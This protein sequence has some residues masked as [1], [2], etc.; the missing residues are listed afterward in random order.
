MKFKNHLLVSAYC[1]ALATLAGAD[2][3]LTAY[4]R[5]TLAKLNSNEALALPES[6]E[7]EPGIT[8][9]MN[10]DFDAEKADVDNEVDTLFDIFYKD[11]DFVKISL[12]YSFDSEGVLTISLPTNCKAYKE[13]DPVSSDEGNT[14]VEL[15][16]FYDPAVDPDNT[17]ILQVPAGGGLGEW[18]YYL[19]GLD[20][21]WSELNAV[22][23]LAGTTQHET[24]SVSVTVKSAPCERVDLSGV[25]ASGINSATQ[26][27]YDSF[28][29]PSIAPEERHVFS[30]YSVNSVIW[31]EPNLSTATIQNLSVFSGVAF[32][33]AAAGTLISDRHLVF[34][35]HFP[36]PLNSEIRFHN[37]F[38]EVEL[39]TLKFLSARIGSDLQIGIVDPPLSPSVR[40][41]K[42]PS[43]GTKGLFIG[44]GGPVENE[45][46]VI[47]LH[48]RGHK[49]TPPIPLLPDDVYPSTL[50]PIH[51]TG[52]RYWSLRRL[53]D[54]NHN[55]GVPLGHHIPHDDRGVVTDMLTGPLANRGFS[56]RSLDTDSGCPNFFYVGGDLVLI[57]LNTAPGKSED[58]V[59]FQTEGDDIGHYGDEIWAAAYALDDLLDAEKS[60]GVTYPIPTEGVQLWLDGNAGFVH[61]GNGTGMARWM[62]LSGHQRDFVAATGGWSRDDLL[63]PSEAGAGGNRAVRFDGISDYLKMDGGMTARTV[64]A[65][66][67]YAEAAFPS[68]STGFDGLFTA[69]GLGS[70][71]EGLFFVGQGGTS[72]LSN[73]TG[74][75]SRFVN[76]LPV[77]SLPAGIPNLRQYNVFSG[78]A[79][80]GQPL[81]NWELGRDRGVANRL[82]SG[83]IAEVI[84]YDRVLKDA[85]RQE[86]EKYLMDKYWT[87]PRERL[88]LWLDS[89]VGFVH[90]GNGT[91]MARWM[92]LSGHQRDFVAA[93]GGWNPD[94]FLL[95]SEAGA[96]GNRAV[97]F[98]GIS[99][100]LK[101]DGGM[102]AKTVFAVARYAE[103]VFP[104]GSTGF[105]GLFTAGGLGSGSEGLFFVGQGGTSVLSNTTGF[106]SRFVN[107]T[108]TAA[109]LKLNQYNVFSGIATNGLLLTNWELGRDRGVA[110]R[111]WNGEIAEVIVYDRVLDDAERQ[112]VEQSLMNKFSPGLE[113]WLDANQGFETYGGG[114]DIAIWKDQSGHQRD[115]VSSAGK[116]PQLLQPPE[117]E[118]K[119][120]K[121]LRFDGNDDFMTM[122]DTMLAQT[123]F[124]VARNDNQL[125]GPHDEGLFTG[126]GMALSGSDI[127]FTG[128][129]G[130]SDFYQ[131]GPLNPR[132]VNG[133]PMGSNQ[134]VPVRLDQ[135]N[136]YSATAHPDA[137][138]CCDE[139]VVGRDRLLTNTVHRLW[140]GE[141]AEV[142]V[143]DHVLSDAERHEVERYLMD[144]Y[145]EVIPTRKLQLWLDANQGFEEDAGGLAVWRDRSGH[146]RDFVA[147]S[148]GESPNNLLPPLSTDDGGN[149]VVHAGGNRAVQFDGN[150]HY[151][152]MDGE[153]SAKTVFAVARYAEAAFPSEESTGFDGLFTAGGLGS[154]PEGLFFVGQGGT[155]ALSNTTGFNS[156]FVNGTPT[157]AI[158]KLNQY[159]VFSG[160]ATS[161]LLLTNWELGRDRGVANRLWDGEI[162]EVIV[163]DRV[164]DDTEREE[165]EQYLIDKY[166]IV[167]NPT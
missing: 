93:T 1:W 52:S 138:P 167:I 27:F 68:G 81:T 151:L 57:Y 70:G 65:V 66:A 18:D 29:D 123:V 144:K 96:G 7:M 55:F 164:L 71:S 76:G 32:D 84:V 35:N 44:Q 49:N 13:L 62:D 147:A 129:V 12:S 163:Y 127:F 128:V 108:P 60:V 17:D 46:L 146:Q 113:L 73:T 85:E 165:V 104:S 28:E 101:M 48:N 121:A 47:G 82:W 118:A 137:V 155:S 112:K 5:G 141:I 31:N 143:Y 120:N 15:D 88:E 159:N 39:T 6:A 16:L 166:Q 97:R 116:S 53:A 45:A 98:D 37:S 110:N 153:M 63:L 107:G 69:G 136:V 95:P 8:L 77:N 64:F 160:I 79:V 106:N 94:D 140:T 30:E 162:A 2:L 23:D 20:S 74:F 50:L 124:V 103:A 92:D 86:V 99:D 115:F 26:T 3:S 14:G 25:D 90:D 54:W 154:G 114:L 24:A 158:L 43:A 102:T 111:L 22:F 67:R 139:W 51:S 42:I 75:N 78:I 157:A 161:G 21:G 10:L 9:T 33:S 56:H 87:I 41:Y 83:E 89:N 34:V 61:D 132:F 119:G 125:F 109:I 126:A 19:R 91:G 4:E 131:Y 130:F 156:R 11:N 152:K 36:R 59:V 72:A 133:Q 135:Y 100:Y 150:N 40:R 134:F 80:N 58:G 142:I 145:L 122:S 105:D 149:R 117:A 148:V 38:G